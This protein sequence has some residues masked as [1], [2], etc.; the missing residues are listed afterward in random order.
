VKSIHKHISGTGGVRQAS[1]P[2]LISEILEEN[3]CT[4]ST[5][6]RFQCEKLHALL[7]LQLLSPLTAH[8]AGFRVAFP[9][10]SADCKVKNQKV[11]ST[12]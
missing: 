3:D 7:Y 11:R 8:F 1:D 6:V 5:A 9:P 12:T 4:T 10:A 2:K